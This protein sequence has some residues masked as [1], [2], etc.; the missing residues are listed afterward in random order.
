MYDI[1]AG[2]FAWRL[3]SVYLKLQSFWPLFIYFY[4]KLLLCC[5][6]SEKSDLHFFVCPVLLVWN[7]HIE[8]KKKKSVN[9]MDYVHHCAVLMIPDSKVYGANMGPIWGRQDP[10]GPHVGHMNLAIWDMLIMSSAS[11]P[12]KNVD[13]IDLTYIQHPR[14]SFLFLI[15]IFSS[16]PRFV[17][18]NLFCLVLY[19]LFSL[20][21]ITPNFLTLNHH[22]QTFNAP[23]FC[24]TLRIALL[25]HHSASN[26]LR[27]NRFKYIY[28]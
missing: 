12:Y 1:H 23:K 8:N 19:S 21:W 6:T 13:G 26:C 14:S 20:L 10:G 17:W 2:H 11:R 16:T 7:I 5:N 25:S 15:A 4:H 22:A 9:I 3:Y 27:S 24:R 28:I 18:Q